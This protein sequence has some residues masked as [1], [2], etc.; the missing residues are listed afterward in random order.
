A[1]GTPVALPGPVQSAVDDWCPAPTVGE[2]QVFFHAYRGTALAKLW[3]ATRASTTVPFDA[4]MSLT[5]TDNPM[6]QEFAPTLTDDGLVLI[7]AEST[8]MV[9]KLQITERTS[10]TGTFGTPML[11][12][13][14]NDGPTVD[15]SYPFVTGDGLDL[16]FSSTRGPVGAGHTL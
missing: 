13:N 12:A 1:F 16:V 8:P 6:R 3:F 14:V 2:T 9:F 11:L 7:Y 10:A 15:D 4:A 5:A